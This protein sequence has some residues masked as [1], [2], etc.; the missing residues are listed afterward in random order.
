MPLDAPGAPAQAAPSATPEPQEP[1]QIVYRWYHKLGAVLFVVIW[2]EVGVILAIFPWS[3]QWQNNYFSWL[4]QDWHNLW[5]NPYFRG[6]ISG[7]GVINVCLSLI[8][9]LRL[10]RFAMESE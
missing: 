5:V 4:S 7:L 2:L 1:P 8:D 10:R 6:A 9:V 3:L